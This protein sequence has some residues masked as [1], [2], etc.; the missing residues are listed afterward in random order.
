MGLDQ[1][2]AWDAIAEAGFGQGNVTLEA[3]ETVAEGLVISQQPAAGV[4]MVK[5]EPISLVVSSG[6]ARHR[7]EFV[8]GAYT[9]TDAR[10]LAEGKGGYLACV[11]SQAEWDQVASQLPSG[12][13]SV[14]WLGGLRA[15]SGNF[16]WITGEKFDYQRWAN[17][18]PNNEGGNENCLC[19]LKVNDVWGWYDTPDNLEGIYADY[20]MGLVIEYDK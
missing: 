2:R 11:T 8:Q 15:P 7:Y 4:E 9:W 18:E 14:V 16:E 5:G 13:V 19:L 3:S 10:S 1:S 12:D 17:G 20:R 6:P